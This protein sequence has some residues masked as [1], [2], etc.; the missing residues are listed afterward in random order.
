MWDFD[1]MTADTATDLP[2]AAIVDAGGYLPGR[3]N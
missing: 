3:T 2:G 1:Q